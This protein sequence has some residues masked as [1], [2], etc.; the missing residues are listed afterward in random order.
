MGYLSGTLLQLR[1]FALPKLDQKNIVVALHE[2]MMLIVDDDDRYALCRVDD[3]FK[4]KYVKL[5]T[6]GELK[7]ISFFNRS[8]S[9]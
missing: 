6:V 1:V 5:Y 2:K 8:R 9:I 7:Q 4:D 3:F